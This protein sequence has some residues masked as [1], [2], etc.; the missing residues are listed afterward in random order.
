VDVTNSESPVPH[1]RLVWSRPRPAQA[2]RPPL[3]IDLA[4]AI[5]THLR[6]GDGLTDAQFARMFA[7]GRPVDVSSFR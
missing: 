1:L 5:E 6:G 7:T 4:R 3:R 2:R